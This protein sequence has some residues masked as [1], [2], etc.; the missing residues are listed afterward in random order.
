[1][2]I[3]TKI[4]SGFPGIGK[5]YLFENQDK[6][7]LTV[8]DSDSSNFSWKSEGIRE[9]SFP[10]NYISH[11]IDN[12]D[13]ADIILV[14]SHDVVRKALKEAGLR[15]EIVY[16]HIDN[17]DEY[18]Q[19]YI[20]R[21]NNGAFVSLLTTNWEDWIKQIQVDSYPI[22]HV[23]P[24]NYYLEHLLPN[25]I[26]RCYLCGA[27]YAS[28]DNVFKRWACIDCMDVDHGGGNI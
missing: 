1:M 8:L 20:N 14:S 28:Y 21:G 23:L 27:N 16:P 5:S 19:R 6:Y 11:I 22:H 9:P 3:K 4:I 24:A 10:D 26:R 7:G 12:T 13:M 2:K 25:I 15:Y 18:I 17:K